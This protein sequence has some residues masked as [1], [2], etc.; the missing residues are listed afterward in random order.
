MAQSVGS[1]LHVEYVTQ[2]LNTEIAMTEFEDEVLRLLKQI[3]LTLKKAQ[4]K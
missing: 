4:E 3:L 1:A 2:R